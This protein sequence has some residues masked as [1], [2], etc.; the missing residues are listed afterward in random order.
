MKK[1]LIAVTVL[2]AALSAL[3]YM[4]AMDHADGVA[5]RIVGLEESSGC[6]GLSV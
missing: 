3:S 2:L 4:P 6:S 1:V 5:V